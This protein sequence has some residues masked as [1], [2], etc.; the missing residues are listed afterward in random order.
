MQVLE[1]RG[2][3]GS[4]KL[5]PPPRKSNFAKFIAALFGGLNTLL[6]ASAVLSFAICGIQLVYQG[7]ASFD[8]VCKVITSYIIVI[9]IVATKLMKILFSSIWE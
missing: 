9:I 2:K 8:D 6:L 4:N 1:N 5:V 7:S 3:Y